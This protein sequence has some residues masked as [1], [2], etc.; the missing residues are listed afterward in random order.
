MI[1]HPTLT[2][3][4]QSLLAKIIVVG[5]IAYPIGV[6]AQANSDIVISQKNRAYAPGAV[7]IKK[8]QSIT[9]LNDDIFLH[10]AFIESDKMKF[11]SGSMDEGESVDVKFS[12]P[13]VFN[14]KCAIHPK[15]NLEVT[16]E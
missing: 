14:V 5:A 11:D 15:M 4:R 3:F 9:I 13:G 7:T 6:W 10:H 2:R 12:K 16:V 1:K 8:G